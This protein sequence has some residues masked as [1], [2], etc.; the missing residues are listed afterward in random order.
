MQGSGVRII[1][2]AALLACAAGAASSYAENTRRFMM[3]KTR[4]IVSVP[5]G[6]VATS[7]PL[8]VMVGVDV[9][10]KG[11]NAIDA[12]V[13][14]NAMIGLCEPASCGVGGD[15]FAIYWEAKSGKLYGLNASGRSPYAAS[16]EKARARGLVLLPNQDPLAWSVPGCVD[17][18]AML[19]ERFGTLTL[20][21]LLQ[22]AI[23]YAEKGVP[24]RGLADPGPVYY[25][26]PGFAETFMRDGK[27][28]ANGELFRNPGLAHTYR[29][30]AEGGRDAYYKGEIARTI[31]D[32]SNKTGGLF[33]LRDF[34]DHHGEWVEPVSTDYRGYRVWE[35]PPNGQG[36]AVLQMLNILE[37]YDLA[38]LGHNSAEYLHLFLE[39]KKLAFADR[40][41]F[42]TDPDF[43]KVPVDWL[44]SKE[45]AASRR[46]LI[47]PTKA[48][49]TDAHGEPP[50]HGDTIYLSVADKD[51]N[52]LSFIQSNYFGFGSGYVPTGL[53]FVLQNRGAL[54]ALD[55][56]HPNRLEPHR[57]PFH[58][59]IPAFVTRDG[60]PWLS[61]GVMGGDTQPQGQVQGLC[62]LIDFGMDLQEAGDAPRVRHIGSSQPTGTRMEQGGLVCYEIGIDPEVIRKLEQLGHRTH[63]QG[64]LQFFGG[65][66]AIMRGEEGVYHGASDPRR[67]G[68]AFGY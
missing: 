38:S 15:L 44:V 57:R 36:I 30:L 54:F 41:R 67:A 58:T 19:L 37:G 5:H 8:A 59:I 40:A 3:D 16:L 53:G 32:Y 52:M 49:M 31:V 60:Q 45:Y 17:G 11:G 27:V 7:Q 43:Y 22:P 6:M 55:E 14:A 10:K 21:E 50:H 35:L 65:Y 33:S 2:L 61:F 48:S 29:L 62:N 26:K 1:V 25:D 24:L 20:K 23:E 66:Q 4:E 13:A 18:W 34:A 56:S 28:V 12:A 46:Q 39:A 64:R 42:Y 47:D 9:L 63:P 68:C 51:G